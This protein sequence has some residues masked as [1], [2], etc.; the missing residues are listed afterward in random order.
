[1]GKKK[2]EKGVPQMV[3]LIS[4]NIWHD[5]SDLPGSHFGYSNFSPGVLKFFVELN[6]GKLYKE[7][8]KFGNFQ[9]KLPITGD[10][11]KIIIIFSS[12]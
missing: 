7:K 9:P 5:Y 8:A 10:Q 11:C 6:L 3:I 12:S 4:L 2:I 1:M